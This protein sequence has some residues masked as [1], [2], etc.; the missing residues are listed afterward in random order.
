MT[1]ADPGTHILIDGYGAPPGLLADRIHL[2]RALLEWQ[3]ELGLSV[4]SVP[5]VV[6][7]GPLAG[8]EKAGVAGQVT[9][10]DTHVGF[11][12]YPSRG[13]AT[14]DVHLAGAA[15]DSGEVIARLRTVFGLAETEV[16]VQPLGPR[17]IFAPR[18]ALVG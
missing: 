8:A 18:M 17:P 11:Q 2:T 3:A 5:H 4:V 7:P 14:I 13:F 16:F 1:N 6:S 12:T 15:D 9:I 10:G